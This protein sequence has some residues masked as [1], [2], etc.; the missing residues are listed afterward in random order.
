MVFFADTIGTI[1][2]WS[3]KHNREHSK[4]VKNSSKTTFL[5]ASPKALPS[6]ITLSSSLASLLCFTD[7]YTLTSLPRPSALTTTGRS[8]ASNALTADS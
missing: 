3:T 1:V 5:P 8:K 2:S 4:P 6:S 7:D